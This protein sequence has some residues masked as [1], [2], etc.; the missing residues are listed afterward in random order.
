MKIV[1]KK[2]TKVETK[3][4]GRSSDAISPSFIYGCLGGCYKSYC[5]VNRYNPD[6]VYV[7]ENVRDIL[8]SMI[9]WGAAQRWPKIPNQIHDEFY[10]LDIGCNCDVPLMWKYQPWGTIIDYFNS[11]DKLGITFAT[12][13]PSKLKHRPKGNKLPR[14]RISMMPEK[15]SEILEPNTDSIR[16]RISEFERLYDLGWEVH[17]NFSPVVVYDGW[18]ED[19]ARLFE[20]MD[21]LIPRYV[22]KQIKAE[23]IFLT[24]SDLQEDLATPEQLEL[25]KSPLQEFKRKN[26]LRYKWQIKKE[27]IN[28][29]KSLLP[30][31]CEIRYVF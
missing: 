19:Y 2:L 26:V 23:I 1:K 4:N 6:T 27:L 8:S 17:V 28:E 9:R 29:F 15:I 11:H 3:N 18:Q 22:Q 5:Y 25:L 14:V 30:N 13:Y 31:W 24:Y 10:L 12:K 20:K 7:Y 21:L 16:T